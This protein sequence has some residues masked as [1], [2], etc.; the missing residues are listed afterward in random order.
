MPSALPLRGIP[1]FRLGF[2][3]F[4]LGGAAVAAAIVPLWVALR[5][6]A[7]TDS[8][9]IAPL[10]WHAHEMLFGFA[11]AIIIG[12]LFT[13]GRTWTGL[14]TPRGA[15]LASLF[16]IWLSAR[17]LAWT[18]PY[19]LFVGMDL[20][21]L[22]VA[23]GLFLSVLLRARSYRNLPLA[24]ILLFLWVADIAFHL[25]LLEVLTTSAFTPIYAGLA[26]IIMME[27]I[28]GGRIIPAFTSNSLVG[29][30]LK[31]SAQLERMTLTCTVIALALWVTAPPSAIGASALAV[32]SALHIARLLQWKP[33]VALRKPML[34]VLHVSY[35]WIPIGLALLA[36]SQVGLV[37][38]P[39]GVHALAVGATGG[40]I[41]G[42]IA[43]TARGHTGRPIVA[44]TTETIAFSCVMCAALVRVAWPL[45]APESLATSLVT[46]ATLWSAAFILYLMVFTPWLMRTRA[47]GQDG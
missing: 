14:Q 31:V 29:A 39:A 1:L 30:P 16:A 42:M 27:C 35:A 7:L 41:I 4:Y 13:A 32:A 19:P 10:F 2:R 25:T 26:L 46:A 6:G 38:Q 15:L 44:S 21:L 22:P 37:H 33:W 18:G 40:L 3:P 8:P 20:L 11:V 43:R 12:F 24:C 23:T 45:I 28:V 36:L 9:T 5:L 17:V 47:D 34:L